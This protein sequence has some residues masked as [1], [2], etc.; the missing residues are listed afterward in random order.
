MQLDF[1]WLGVVS[2]LGADLHEFKSEMIF[3]E[4]FSA[5]DLGYYS[6]FMLQ[7]EEKVKELVA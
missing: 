6:Y 3:D 1:V 5:E 7:L 2:R 4:N